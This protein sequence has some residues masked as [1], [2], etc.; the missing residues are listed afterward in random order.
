MEGSVY[1]QLTEKIIANKR[2]LLAAFQQADRNRNGINMYIRCEEYRFLI[3]TC[4]IKSLGVN[5][6][7]C[8]T[9]E[10]PVAYYSFENSSRRFER[11]SL[12]NDVS[13]LYF[14]QF[15]NSNSSHFE[16]ITSCC[17]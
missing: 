6:V 9:N 1:R 5:Y 8:F 12:R 13:R 7:E 3:R 17:Q 16:D 10:P 11:C 14:R 2:S 15:K 4:I